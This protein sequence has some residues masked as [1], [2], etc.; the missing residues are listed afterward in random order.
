MPRSTEFNHIIARKPAKS[1]TSGLRAH[2][3]ADPDAALFAAQHEQYL[4]ALRQSGVAALVL[5]ALEDFPDSV[6]IEDAAICIQGTAIVTNP[7]TS[8]RAGEGI[9]IKPTLEAKFEHVFTLPPQATLDGGDV[10]LTDTDAF[11]G[12]SARTNEAGY[13]ELSSILS[14]FGYTGRQVNTPKSILHFKSDCGLLDP[15]TIF[16]T[17]ALA[18]TGA[19]DGYNIIATPE[20]ESAAANIICVNG[21]VFI[22]E[23]FPQSEKLLKKSGYKVVSLN[24]SEAAKVDGG[25]SCM[26][27][28]YSE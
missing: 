16:S 19:F 7:G 27:L 8:T 25:L 10:L 28:R 14:Q 5:P 2:N 12:L 4:E 1:V 13:N 15:N 26:S 20:A 23:G 11:I 6:F 3:G 24:T 17:P 22:S 18:A 9:A 21:T